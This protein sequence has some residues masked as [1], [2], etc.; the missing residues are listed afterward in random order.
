[1]EKIMKLSRKKLRHMI[2]NEIKLLKEGTIDFSD[3]AS[4]IKSKP[5]ERE[6]NGKKESRWSFIFKR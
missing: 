2:L 5:G 6:Y 1:M 3:L 4:S